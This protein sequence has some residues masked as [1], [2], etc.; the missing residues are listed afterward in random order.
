ME[1]DNGNSKPSAI[2]RVKRRSES[3]GV[4][5]RLVIDVM[6]IVPRAGA[7]KAAM[8]SVRHNA[9]TRECGVPGIAIAR[10]RAIRPVAGGADILRGAEPCFDHRIHAQDGLG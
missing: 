8:L 2:A 1:T 9:L 6:W 10:F 5:S 3:R 4:G 7:A